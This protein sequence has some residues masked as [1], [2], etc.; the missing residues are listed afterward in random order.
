MGR[1]ESFECIEFSED[2]FTGLSGDDEET[3]ED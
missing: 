1:E 3:E 2:V